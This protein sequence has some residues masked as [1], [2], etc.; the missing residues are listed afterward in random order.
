MRIR[1]DLTLHIKGTH[2]VLG[3]TN[4]GQPTPKHSVVTLLQK[5]RG[6]KNP[7][8]TRQKEQGI[9]GG[10]K[11]VLQSDVDSNALCQKEHT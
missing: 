3:N 9:R 6:E 11:I 8:G 10:K 4:P 7:A 2:H 5:N 1:K